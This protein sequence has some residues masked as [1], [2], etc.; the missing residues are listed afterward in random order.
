[1]RHW[2]LSGTGL[3]RGARVAWLL[4]LVACQ[5]PPP[6]S[7]TETLQRFLRLMDESAVR[8]GPSGEVLTD[9]ESLQQAYALLS[10]ATQGSLRERAELAAALAGGDYQPWNVLIPGRF[11]LRFAPVSYHEVIQASHPPRALVTVRGRAAGEVAEIALVQEEGLWRI[12]IDIPHA[13]APS[14]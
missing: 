12:P 9:E 7:P 13:A 8:S 3:A 2:I 1:M 4:A 14:F 5:K 11:R 6:P 10:D